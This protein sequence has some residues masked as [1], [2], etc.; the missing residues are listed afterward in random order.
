MKCPKCG[1]EIFENSKVCP[2]CGMELVTHEETNSASLNQPSDVLTNQLNEASQ[3]TNVMQ[4]QSTEVSQPSGVI[5][6]QL[7]EV[8]Q[9]NNVMPN[10]SNV[11]TQLNQ[12][13]K[14]KKNN[15]L[16]WIILALA[17]VAIVLFLVFQ[18]LKKSPKEVF[19]SAIDQVY[20][21]VNDSVVKNVKTEKGTYSLKVT[22]DAKDSQAKQMLDFINKI[23]LSGNYEVDNENM[24]MNMAFRSKYDKDTLL[25]MDF[26]LNGKKGY[27]YLPGVY[28]KYIE[29]EVETTNNE[30]IDKKELTVALEELVKAFKKSLKDDYFTSIDTKINVNGKEKEVKKITLEL[31]K[32]RANEMTKVILTE[33]KDNDRFLEAI[34]NI[35]K[36]SKEDIKNELETSLADIDDTNLENSEIY[37]FSLYVTGIKQNIIG[38]Q[39]DVVSDDENQIIQVQVENDTYYYQFIDNEDEV[40]KGNIQ[41]KDDKKSGSNIL[42]NASITNI[43][44]IKLEMGYTKEENVKVNAKEITN[45][46]HSDMLTEKDSQLILQGLL[47]NKGFIKLVNDIQKL[48]NPYGY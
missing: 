11:V 38:Y 31:T 42:I 18:F 43:A 5:S 9:L 32:A 33:L 20:R 47:Q 19:E 39:I 7:N 16:V 35:K 17:I 44:D 28:N 8:S 34:S 27:L 14:K 10:Q 26:Y 25:D 23:S 6:N 15:K 24:V 22:V 29:T 30:K 3:S 2:V 12:N 41:I 13:E 45:T 21:A 48:R 37:N 46:I 4:N 36:E 40:L 1:V